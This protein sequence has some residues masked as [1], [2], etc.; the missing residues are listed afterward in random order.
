M[1]NYI[2]KVLYTTDNIDTVIVYQ[3]KNANSAK[4]RVK[5]NFKES[6][7]VVS[8]ISCQKATQ[9]MLDNTWGAIDING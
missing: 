8:I 5:D 9:Q 3:S 1:N 6:G 2:I 7:Y 4:Q